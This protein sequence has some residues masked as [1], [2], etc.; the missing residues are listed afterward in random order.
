MFTYGPNF[1]IICVAA[2]QQLLT[3]SEGGSEAG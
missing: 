1:A 2:T 3:V